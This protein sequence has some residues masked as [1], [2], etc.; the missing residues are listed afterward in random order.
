M[1]GLFIALYLDE[2]VGTLLA[3]LLSAKGF[4]AL[5]ARDAGMLG[6]LDR[7]Q[8]EFATAEGRTVYT[9]NRADFDQLA[10]QYADAGLAHGG[11]ICAVRKPTHELL[12]RLLVI[13]D[14]VTADEMMN[15]VR[16]L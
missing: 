3:K 4:D 16:Y 6:R 7:E 10:R 2:D 9:H 11:I 5:T 1:N 12:S 13:L 8:L 15:A 14:N